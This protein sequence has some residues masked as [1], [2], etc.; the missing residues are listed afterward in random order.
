M[1]LEALARQNQL[2]DRLPD[3]VLQRLLPRGTL[4]PLQLGSLLCEEGADLHQAWFPLQGFVSLL[5]S[6]PDHP[7]LELGMAGPEG[8]V[9]ATL[10]LGATTAPSSGLVQGD[11][12]AWCVQ[13]PAL[14]QQLR[15]QPALLAVLHRYL[16]VQLLQAGQ[17]AACLRFH[18]IAP[19][20]AR[21]LLM[22][23]DRASSDAFFVTHAF[24]A[25]MLGVRRVG[26]TLAAQE[27]Q[28]RGLI[29]YHRGHL[30]V[31]DRPGL[32]TAACSCYQRQRQAYATQLPGPPGTAIA[33]PGD[34]HT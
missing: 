12:Q 18:L 8:C 22:T 13:A 31:L 21:W 19:R 14:H 17:A 27:L 25:S 30:Q 9:G 6:T 5:T 23:Q 7:S 1:P 33:S 4:V 28:N 26:V 24:L 29:H 20:L 15:Q 3:Q 10:A 2:L 16:F 11:G 32:L 34:A